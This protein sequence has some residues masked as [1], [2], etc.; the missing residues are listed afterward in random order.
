MRAAR[1]SQPVRSCASA[2]RAGSAARRGGGLG[3]A[4]LG[5]GLARA[6]VARI[7]AIGAPAAS[8]IPDPD[9]GVL[10]TGAPDVASHGR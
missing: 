3:D 4:P 9:S 2:V 1:R 8:G 10:R 7:A 6:L 5:Q